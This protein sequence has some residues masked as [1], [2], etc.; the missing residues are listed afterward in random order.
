MKRLLIA[1]LL[2]FVGASHQASADPTVHCGPGGDPQTRIDG[3][4]V[5]IDAGVLDDDQTVAVL[6]FRGNAY[7]ALGQLQRA[8]EDYDAALDLAPG[9]PE[10]H[11]NRGVALSALGR[12]ELAIADFDEAI[13]R[14]WDLAATY[15]SR[16][17]SYALMGNHARAIEDFNASLRLAPD[18]TRTLL[19]RGM[20][21]AA[22]GNVEAALDDWERD[23]AV[24][25]AARIRYWQAWIRDH[26][27]YYRGPVDGVHSSDL[28]AALAQCARDRHC[29]PI[30]CGPGRSC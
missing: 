3:C 5:I 25:G 15:F 9:I 10:I 7:A 24:G 4:T 1:T 28:S 17:G 20:A 13:R 29:R 8:I 23:M 2:V 21:H 6:F 12:Y 16:G 14:Q 30:E 26:G 18:D 27:G 22:Q 19:R 11:Y